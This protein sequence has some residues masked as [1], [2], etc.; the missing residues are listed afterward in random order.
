MLVQK[1]DFCLFAARSV[2]LI[3]SAKTSPEGE[4]YAESSTLYITAR[5]T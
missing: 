4:I 2:I 1:V 5:S 3:L